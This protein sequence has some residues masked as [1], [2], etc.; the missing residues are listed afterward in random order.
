MRLAAAALAIA[1]AGCEAANEQASAPPS[2]AAAP[3][4]AGERLTELMPDGKGLRADLPFGSA[5]E[6]VVAAATAERGA[7]TTEEKI[8][9]CGEGPLDFVRYDGL[10]LAFD[11]DRFAGWFVRAPYRLR[12]GSGLRIGSPA[13]DLRGAKVEDS[14]LG[15]E[16]EMPDG[17]RG[18]LDEER[19]SVEALWAGSACIF[20]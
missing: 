6:R 8:E 4:V 9:E 7:P 5:R 3:A 20:R 11:G 12:T 2:N 13:G 18:I 15:A 17:T 10:S 16:F 19:R 1:L 14:S